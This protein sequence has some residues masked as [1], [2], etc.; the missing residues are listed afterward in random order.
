MDPGIGRVEW[1]PHGERKR[2]SAAYW[3]Q[4]LAWNRAAAA[5]GRVERVFPSLCD[6]FD[7]RPIR[8]APGIFRP[9][10][11]D[12]APAMAADA[13]EAAAERGPDVRGSRRLAGDAALG[14]SVEDQK[15]AINLFLLALAARALRARIGRSPVSNHCWAR[16]IRPGSCFTRVP[17]SSLVTLRSRRRGSSSTL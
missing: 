15:R 7:N 8:H 11:G 4:P 3:R 17:L 13:D 12:P 5:A 14:T 1:G 16:L 6:P 10:P 9:D 2:T